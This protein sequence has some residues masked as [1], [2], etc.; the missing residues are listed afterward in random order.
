MKR[1]SAKAIGTRGSWYATVNGERLPCVHQA[2]MQ[3]NLTYLA[4]RVSDAPHDK[5][6]AAINDAGKVIVRKSVRTSDGN[7]WDAK[8]YVAVWSVTD[9]K[10]E[11]DV[12]TFRFIDRL[13]D[14]NG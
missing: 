11:N 6:F 2:N 8:G 13:V 3:S 14:L 9:L 4:T 7:S 12:L 5:L 1:P 10:V